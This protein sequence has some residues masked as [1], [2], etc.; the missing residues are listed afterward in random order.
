M[1]YL[2]A[3]AT[4]TILSMMAFSYATGLIA[5]RFAHRSTLLYRARMAAGGAAVIT[6]SFWLAS[7]LGGAL[8]GL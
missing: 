6:G 3:F 7:S 2:L 4:G 1:E 8:R 5:A